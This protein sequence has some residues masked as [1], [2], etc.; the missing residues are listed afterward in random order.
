MNQWLPVLSPKKLFQDMN[1]L[2]S[3]DPGLVLLLICLRLLSDA[4]YS[5]PTQEYKFAKA[6]SSSAENE[7]IVSLRLIQS[8][9]LLAVY[10]LGNGIYPSVYLT[11]GRAARLAMLVGIHDRK[12]APQLFKSGDTFTLQE[13][14]RRTWWAIFILD[15]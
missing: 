5:G 14:E 9:V 13:E 3:D 4:D 1:T 7:G 11:I 10:E 8:L 12:G 6:L 15:R 2:P